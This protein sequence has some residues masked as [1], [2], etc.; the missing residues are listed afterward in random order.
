MQKSIGLFSISV[1]C[2]AAILVTGCTSQMAPATSTPT[3]TT[4]STPIV[5]TTLNQGNVA[6][7]TQFTTTTQAQLHPITTSIT[8]PPEDIVCLMYH[9]E[10]AFTYN[11]DETSFNLVNPPM[12]IYYTILDTQKGPDGKY[13]SYYTITI[14]D[15][16]TGVIYHKV[17]LGKDTHNGGYFNLGFG[18]YDIIKIMNTGDLQI[19]TEGKDIT[20]ITNI[21][22]KPAGNLDS[23]FD[24]NSTKCMNWPETYRKGGAIKSM[25]VYIGLD[26]STE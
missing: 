22:A 6:A 1:V 4:T 25:G 23:S 16:K 12:Y 14:R 19:E 17:G 10:Q 18:G 21:W 20:I 11:K 24:L 15:K 9:K 8:Q 13:A 2:I 26:T 3:P 7:S 5:P